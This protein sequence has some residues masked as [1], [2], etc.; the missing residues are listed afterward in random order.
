MGPGR[1]HLRGSASSARPCPFGGAG[2]MRRA[3]RAAS[4][5]PSRR[6]RSLFPRRKE[7]RSLAARR[8]PRATRRNRAPTQPSPMW[9]ALSIRGACEEKSDAEGKYSTPPCVGWGLWDVTPPRI[10]ARSA[11]A[12]APERGKRPAASRGCGSRNGAL[13]HTT[14]CDPPS[15][16]LE[17]SVRRQPV[18]PQVL[19][20][21]RNC[22]TSTS[23]P[24]A[25]RQAAT[26][27]PSRKQTLKKNKGNF[28]SSALPR[29]VAVAAA[30]SPCG[31]REP[32]LHSGESH[33]TTPS[34]QRYRIEAATS[35][36]PT[37]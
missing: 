8:R 34:S 35:R 16:H 33:Q 24:L 31:V 37:T 32:N 36:P 3:Q 28:V 12:G 18:A 30:T 6:L 7:R 25:G 19:V 21:R 14:L 17:Q 29:P 10:P 22:S 20:A 1:R 27:P 2:L 11:R 23:P 15:E 13:R 4:G 5:G 9:E 26:F